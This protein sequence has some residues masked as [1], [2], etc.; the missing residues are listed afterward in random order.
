MIAPKPPVVVTGLKTNA[1]ALS[2]TRFAL[3]NAARRN[4]GA[5]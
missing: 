2:K 5:Q 3:H 1:V 4:G